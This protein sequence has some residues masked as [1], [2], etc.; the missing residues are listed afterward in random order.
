MQK[1]L[2]KRPVKVPGCD[3]LEPG[4]PYIKD[5]IRNNGIKLLEEPVKQNLRYQPGSS[6]RD[7]SFKDDDITSVVA[8]IGYKVYGQRRREIN[9]KKYT[10]DCR[11]LKKKIEMSTKGQICHESVLDALDKFRA[12]KQ[13]GRASC[14]ERV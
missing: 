10:E 2:K 7:E 6:D 5:S 4:D 8:C 9:S 14:R 3:L 11:K 13:I 1:D 12:T